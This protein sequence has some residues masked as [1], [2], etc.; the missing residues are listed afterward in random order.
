VGGSFQLF[1]RKVKW[2]TAVAASFH[3]RIYLQRIQKIATVINRRGNGPV[4][5]LDSN[6]ELN[7]FAPRDGNLFRVCP[8]V[9]AK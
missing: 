3:G 8:L 9:R 6:A 4:E 1:F 2:L 7:D 5:P